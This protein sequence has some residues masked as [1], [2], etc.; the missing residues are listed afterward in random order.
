MKIKEEQ[1]YSLSDEKYSLE[2][3]LADQEEKY[4]EK[5]K[6]IDDNWDFKF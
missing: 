3:E 4:K 6:N 5:I 2:A 1:V